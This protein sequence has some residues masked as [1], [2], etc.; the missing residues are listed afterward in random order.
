MYPERSTHT[1]RPFAASLPCSSACARARRRVEGASPPPAARARATTLWPFAAH[2]RVHPSQ[3]PSSPGHPTCSR[4]ERPRESGPSRVQ[5][6]G[7]VRGHALAG[8]A[9]GLE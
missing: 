4:F 2:P 5:G 7:E 3:Y 8:G 9:G 1:T 6:G